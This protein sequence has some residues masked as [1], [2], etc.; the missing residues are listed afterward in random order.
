MKHYLTGLIA[1]IALS[2]TWAAPAFAQATGLAEAEQA[3]V[4]LDYENARDIARRTV[5]AGGSN[6]AD[7]ARLFELIGTTSAILED[8]PAAYDAY[9]RLMALRPD[10]EMDQSLPPTLRTPFLRARGWWNAQRSRFGATLTVG[11]PGADQPLGF[12]VQLIDPLS[13]AHTVR[14]A[15]RADGETEYHE[16]ELEAR[17][18][19]VFQS[20]ALGLSAA[21]LQNTHRFDYRLTILDQWGNTVFEHGT[22]AA[23]EHVAN[24]RQAILLTQTGSGSNVTAPQGPEVWE[25]WW[26]WTI[27]GVVVAAGVAVGTYF[28]I[29][30]Q[31]NG[32][33][34]VTF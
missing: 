30:P 2:S 16:Q 31:I 27:I 25:E 13:L 10:A 19:V 15:V 4:N 7:T 21:S 22:V 33:V 20:D 12:I 18:Q 14:L 24:P 28:A 8:E 1:S 32:R 23:P 3:F 26:F 6:L 5:E 29:P 9:R 17:G 34:G 11:D